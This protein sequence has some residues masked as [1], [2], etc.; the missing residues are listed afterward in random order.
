MN[1]TPVDY[2]S[3]IPLAAALNPNT[4]EVA[5]TLEIACDDED[6][7]VSRPVGEG[8]TYKDL[9]GSRVC[10]SSQDSDLGA[11]PAGDPDN[12]GRNTYGWCESVELHLLA[13]KFGGEPICLGMY[14]S[15]QQLEA[16]KAAIIASINP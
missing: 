2:D 11:V 13:K 3:D 4:F 9:E 7:I 16:A 10:F 6:Q 8:Y 5:I 14:R 15:E 12:E 1:P